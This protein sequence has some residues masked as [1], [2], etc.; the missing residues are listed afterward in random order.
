MI[1]VTDLMLGDMTGVELCYRIKQEHPAVMVLVLSMIDD[2]AQI[3]ETIQLGAEGYI[4]KTDDP[5]EVARGIHEV[6][7]QRIPF[8]YKSVLRLF[9][10][11]PK[12]TSDTDAL[13]TLTQR[14][15]EILILIVNEKTKETIAEQLFIS[16]DT[17]ETHRRNLMKKICVKSA[18]GLTNFAHRHGLIS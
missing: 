14:E 2:P 10:A 5:T 3:R 4:L 12:P 9:V 8:F 7:R 13:P 17:V 1:V 16:I 6:Y 18:I 15:L 11:D